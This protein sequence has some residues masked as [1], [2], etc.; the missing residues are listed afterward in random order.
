MRKI[1]RITL[2]ISAVAL[3]FLS[4][5]SP[6]EE[7]TWTEVTSF[8][9]DWENIPGYYPVAYGRDS[10]GRVY[11]RGAVK[12]Y[13]SP[14]AT[15]QTDIFTLPAEYRPERAMYFTITFFNVSN[16]EA[17]RLM[18]YPSGNVEIYPYSG[19][20]I[21]TIYIGEVSFHL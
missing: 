7:I 4:C 5:P 14:Y 8:Y 11:I 19:S 10:L 20:P 13:N 18:I 21:Q 17:A 2:L 15:G 9:F 6:L 1:I 3:T 12:D 16:Y